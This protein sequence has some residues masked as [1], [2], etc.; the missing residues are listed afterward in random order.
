ML[1]QID[2]IVDY[3]T[4]IG[5]CTKLIHLTCSDETARERLQ[6]DHHVAKNRDFSLYLNVKA[7][8]E[9]IQREHLTLNTDNSLS[10]ALIQ[11][12]LHYL[13]GE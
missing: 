2:R 1:Y 12:S 11:E 6:L 9:A 10:D 13:R 7:S 4:Q 3:A 8:F 5:C